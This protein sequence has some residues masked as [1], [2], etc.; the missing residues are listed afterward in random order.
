MLGRMEICEGRLGRLRPKRWAGALRPAPGLW[1]SLTSCPSALPL[2]LRPWLR[3]AGSCSNCCCC[4]CCCST[5]A[6]SRALV[7]EPTPRLETISPKS[8]RQGGSG[9]RAL[10]PHPAPSL[11]SPAII[12][13]P[14]HHDWLLSSSA[15]GHPFPSVFSPS[16]S[17]RP[18]LRHLLPARRPSSGSGCAARGADAVP[19]GRLGGRAAL[20][21]RGQAS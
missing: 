10:R 18:S 5:A 12:F 7:W 13:F 8:S 20:L 3:W 4:C 14:F 16:S 15:L 9:P 17:L 21:R 1:P 6:R 11:R 2:P 19:E